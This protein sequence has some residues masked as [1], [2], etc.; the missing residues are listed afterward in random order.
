V[1]IAGLVLA[2]L[3]AC[4][5]AAF[6]TEGSFWAFG[7]VVLSVVLPFVNRPMEGPVLLHLPSERGVTLSDLIA[8]L[9]FLLGLFLLRRARRVS[10]S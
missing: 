6:V 5:L 9:S 2:A 1:L 7:V 8:L 4:V 3:A 10:S